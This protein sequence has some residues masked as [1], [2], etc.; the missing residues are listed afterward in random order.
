MYTTTAHT[1][2][3]EF[4][5]DLG[6][7]KGCATLG[8]LLAACLLLFLTSF[9]ALQKH[10]VWQK[11]TAPSSPAW[12]LFRGLVRWSLNSC[13]CGSLKYTVGSLSAMCL[14]FW[15]F[16]VMYYHSHREPLIFSPQDRKWFPTLLFCWA[17]RVCRKA[18]RTGRE[19]LPA[20]IKQCLNV[21]IFLS[22]KHF[23]SCFLGSPRSCVV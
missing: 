7:C 21:T 17:S 3:I 8:C 4:P 10:V 15:Q 16:N 14:L 13:S 19:I 18:K 20:V 1:S 11:H 2:V 5:D 23:P 12:W 6:P 22:L 9:V